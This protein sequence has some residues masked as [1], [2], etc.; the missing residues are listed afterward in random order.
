MVGIEGEP[1]L[2]G[3]KEKSFAEF[4]EKNFQFVDDCRFQIALGVVRV[5]I[6]PEEFLEHRDL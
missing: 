1:F 6:K 3:F 4:Q 2:P 5:L